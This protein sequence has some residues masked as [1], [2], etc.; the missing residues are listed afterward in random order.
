MSHRGLS[1][2]E[3]AEALRE[4]ADIHDDMGWIRNRRVGTNAFWEV[5]SWDLE[6][7]GQKASDYFVPPPTLGIPG[8][9]TC[10]AALLGVFLESKKTYTGVSYVGRLP[11]L[12]NNSQ[13][14]NLGFLNADD[15]AGLYLTLYRLAGVTHLMAEASSFNY[16]TYLDIDAYLP[17][18]Y[19]TNDNNHY[20]FYVLEPWA[21]IHINNR[22]RA[23]FIG[24]PE[25]NFTDIDAPPYIIRRLPCSIQRKMPIFLQLAGQGA[26]LTWDINLLGFSP[27]EMEPRLPRVFRLY[28]TGTEDLL[29]GLT[30]NSGYRISHPFPALGYNYTLLFQANKD[31]ILD[32]EILTQ[33]NNWRLIDSIPIAADDL[34]P[35]TT[36]EQAVLVRVTFTPSEYPCIINDAEVVLT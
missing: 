9:L 34:K 24:A 1:K 32:V 23:I 30:I 7:V 10:P 6:P 16:L 36:N 19:A 3:E 2:G 17:A 20:D 11:L 25:L 21:E 29:A 5:G 12:P 13:A 15:S 22:L 33:T 4:E 35:Y 14:A 26:Q 28:H 27:K 18:D 31:G 8:V